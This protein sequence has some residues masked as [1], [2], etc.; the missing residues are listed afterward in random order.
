V[1]GSGYIT[2][3]IVT[4]DCSTYLIKVSLFLCTPPCLCVQNVFFIWLFLPNFDL[5][6][7]LY[8]P[9][10]LVGEG[11]VMHPPKHDPP[12]PTRLTCKPAAPTCRRNHHSTDDRCQPAGAQ[13]ATRSRQSAMSQVKPPPAKPFPKPRWRWAN[14]APP[15]GTPDQGRLWYS[16]GSNPRL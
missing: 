13:P 12:T 7:L 9:N 4:I 14:C 11:W 16:L 15:Y 8:L 10:G 3:C 1:I 2:M 6:S 5:V